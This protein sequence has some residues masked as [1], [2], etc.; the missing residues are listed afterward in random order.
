MTAL[1]LHFVTGLSVAAGVVLAVL[2]V[3]AAL[4]SFLGILRWLLRVQLFDSL[5]I[6]AEVGLR[7]VHQLRPDTDLGNPAEALKRI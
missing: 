6:G 5:G 4:E 7:R 2:T 1:V 3:F